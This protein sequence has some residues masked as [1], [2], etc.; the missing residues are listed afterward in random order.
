MGPGALG[1]LA[2]A[3]WEMKRPG[4]AGGLKGLLEEWLL[5]RF[6]K[7][8]GSLR[9]LKDESLLWG[10]LALQKLGGNREI[11]KKGEVW[12]FRKLSVYGPQD[13]LVMALAA[14]FIVLR[15]K[16]LGELAA[17]VMLKVGD[18]RANVGFRRKP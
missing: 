13:G 1:K 9:D 11:L 16:S 14:E 18:W 2:L 3:A 5:G 12:A 17:Q 7:K 8:N 6:S 4:L 10:L 15:G